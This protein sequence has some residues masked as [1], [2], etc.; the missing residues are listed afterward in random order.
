MVFVKEDLRNGML[1]RCAILLDELDS[2]NSE[3]P[4]GGAG[5]VVV[6][7]KTTNTSPLI[8]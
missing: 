6:E 2:R 3:L 7:M 4:P 5:H 1:R 8:K